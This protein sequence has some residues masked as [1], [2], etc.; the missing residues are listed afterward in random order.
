[1]DAQIFIWTT[2]DLKS[3]YVLKVSRTANAHGDGD[4]DGD[5]DGMLTRPNN[6]A[7]KTLPVMAENRFSNWKTFSVFFYSTSIYDERLNFKT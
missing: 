4:G 2:S 6:Q 3:S 5:E 1:M 7:M